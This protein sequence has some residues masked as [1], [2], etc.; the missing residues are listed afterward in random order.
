MVLNDEYTVCVQKILVDV[1]DDNHL[2]IEVYDSNY[3][4]NQQYI[5]VIRTKIFNNIE[6]NNKNNYQYKCTYND[7]K[8][9]VSISIPNIEVNL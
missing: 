9:S 8:V 4:G 2:K 1:K 3:E 6:G 7:K 5:D